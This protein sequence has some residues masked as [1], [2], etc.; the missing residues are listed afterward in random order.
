M[1][2]TPPARPCQSDKG[3]L[4]PLTSPHKKIKNIKTLAAQQGADLAKLKTNIRRLEDPQLILG[5]ETPTKKT[6]HKLRIKGGGSAAGTGGHSAPLA[7]GSLRSVAPSSVQS[8]INHLD[9]FSLPSNSIITK[10]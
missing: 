8:C 10:I 2:L 1:R 7:Y 4:V 9:T 3:A 5:G 6:L